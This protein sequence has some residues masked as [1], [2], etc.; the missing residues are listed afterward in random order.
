MSLQPHLSSTWR[1]RN[2]QVG[3]VEDFNPSIIVNSVD[4][5]M[6]VRQDRQLS[7]GLEL[8]TYPPVVPSSAIRSAVL[9][10]QRAELLLP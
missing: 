4:F 6:S 5:A 7:T 8:E 2:S 10:Y 9:C 3:L 1:E